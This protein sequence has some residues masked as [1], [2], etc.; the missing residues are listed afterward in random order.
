MQ[1]DLVYCQSCHQPVNSNYCGNCG[2]PVHLKRVDSHYVLHE[3]QHLLHL[4]KGILYTIKQLLIHPGKSIREFITSNRGRLVKP[5]LF[6]IL[7]SLTYTSLY[8][9]LHIQEQAHSATTAKLPGGVILVFEWIEHHYGYANLFMGIFIALWLKLFFRKQPYN[10]FE[11]LI[12]L[13]FVMGMGMLLLSVFLLV[14]KAIHTDVTNIASII[15]I[16]YCT[17]AIG[18]FLNKSKAAGY[19]KALVAYLLGYASFYVVASL[20]GFLIQHIIIH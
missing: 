6:I 4:E 13:C 16:I 15:S 2:T 3:I 12:L 8:H 14:Q 1:S 18:Q 7:S 20:L 11:L 10:L 19:L 9:L 17:W 5:V